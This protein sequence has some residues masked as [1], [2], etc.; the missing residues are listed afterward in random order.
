MSDPN[1]VSSPLKSIIPAFTGSP[2]WDSALAG[3]VIGGAGVTAGAAGAWMNAHGFNFAGLD[4]YLTIFFGAI[5]TVVLLI[6]LRFV[7]IGKINV[8]VAA[9]VINAVAHGEISPAVKQTAIIAP[10]ISMETISKAIS[11]SN[12]LKGK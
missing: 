10:E 6:F 4:W 1:N 12:M 9:Q 7:Q 2:Q 8:N 3:I 5:I 11:N